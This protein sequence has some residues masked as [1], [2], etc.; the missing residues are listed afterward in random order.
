MKTTSMKH[1]RSFFLVAFAVALTVLFQRCQTKTNVETVYTTDP[2]VED[3]IVPNSEVPVPVNFVLDTSFTHEKSHSNVNWKSRY[4]DFS[5]TYLT[6]RF[7]EYQFVPDFPVPASKLGGVHNASPL[8]NYNAGV[9]FATGPNTQS[10][11]CYF[12]FNGSDLSKCYMNFYVLVSSCNTS[13]PGRDQ[14]GKCGPNYY[15]V[16]YL[17]SNRNS[18]ST[19]DPRSDTARFVSTS[20]ERQGNGYIVNGNFT[21]NR[22]LP[23][24]GYAD[25][26]PITKPISIYLTYNGSYDFDTNKDGVPDNLK[27]GFSAQFNFN[28]SDFMDKNATAMYWPKPK[29][30]EAAT[31]ATAYA[32]NKTYG[33]WSGSVADQMIINANMVFYKKH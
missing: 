25:G 24:S 28:R 19:V 23:A 22:Y 14:Y 27:C 10:P 32:N 3:V 20:F 5:E 8:F 21:F 16:V 29:A 7:G 31:S 18:T 26:A 17:D 12:R 9:N 4:Y 1:R 13:E 2:K 11:P 6:G 33:V 30:A 15:G